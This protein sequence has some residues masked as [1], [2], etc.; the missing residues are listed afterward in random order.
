MRRLFTVVCSVSL[1][2]IH[3][4]GESLPYS[5]VQAEEN[6]A[7]ITRLLYNVREDFSRLTFFVQGEFEYN[8]EKQQ[9][10]VFIH[11]LNTVVASTPGYSTFEFTTGLVNQ[12]RFVKTGHNSSGAAIHLRDG[13]WVSC[14]KDIE[15]NNLIVYVFPEK[16][17]PYPTDAWSSD[18]IDSYLPH[19]LFSLNIPPIMSE[20][21]SEKRVGSSELSLPGGRKT[22]VESEAAHSHRSLILVF[23][24]IVS[25]MT[26][27]L[28]S[29]MM[30]LLRSYR[31]PR[32]QSFE[33]DAEPPLPD[34]VGEAESSLDI[35]EEVGVCTTSER[36]VQEVD[37]P[38]EIEELAETFG[39]GKGELE[40]VVKMRPSVKHEV[41]KEKLGRAKIRNSTRAAIATLAKKLGIGQGELKLARDLER[42]KEK[43]PN[44]KEERL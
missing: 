31:Q 12:T 42:M 18:F 17:R 9:D 32:K 4:L 11:F 7:H 34:T 13:A 40:L 41:L 33:F 43:N 26:T 44:H 14:F 39:R 29:G 38:S 21:S 23:A 15:Q 27:L 24:V 20:V 8:L 3:L 25:A 35:T 36:H 37:P 28:L 30:L 5:M 22:G 19:E 1:V 16:L 6:Q 10:Y 2:W